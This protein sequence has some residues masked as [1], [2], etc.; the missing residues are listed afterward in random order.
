[1]AAI[2]A[3][4]FGSGLV[5]GFAVTGGLIVGAALI[6]P[7]ALQAVLGFGARRARGPLAQWAWAD[8]RQQL[9]GLTLALM[10]LLLALAVNI[11]VST[12]V[13]SFRATFLA[14]L[15]QRLAAEV[16]VT[17]PSEAERA[18]VAD[19]LAARP[20]VE[21]VLP[22]RRAETAIE[23]WPADVQGLR[24]HATYRESWPLLSAAPGAWDA[25]AAAEGALISEQLARRLGLGPGDAL[26]LPADAGPWTVPVVGVYPDYGNPRGQ[27][28]VSMAA[29]EARWSDVLGAQF[30]VRVEPQAAGRLIADLRAAFGL[31]EREAVDQAAVK[32]LSQAVFERTFAVTVALNALTLAVAGIALFTSLL[33]LAGQRLVQVA[34]VWALGVTRRRLAAIEMGRTLGLAAGTALIALPL[35]LG[36]AWVLSDVVNVEAFGWRIPL[37]LFPGDWAMLFAMALGTAFLAALLPVMRLRRAAPID[38]LRGFSNE[39]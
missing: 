10:A 37:R 33:A 39:R 2:A 9:G 36:V 13:G 26:M 28:I 8:G 11:G 18:A 14:Y 1:M 7:A 19:W 16:Y 6:L 29:L 21:A 12:M 5:A 23:G 22:L 34:P 3:L 32:A 30:A 24:D 27:V 15:D 38:L 31:D 35:G 25:V 4:V 20:E 17:L